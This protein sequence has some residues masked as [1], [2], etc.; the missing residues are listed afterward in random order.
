MK[1]HSPWG[2]GAQLPKSRGIWSQGNHFMVGMVPK[3][4][5]KWFAQGHHFYRFD[6]LIREAVEGGWE[7]HS[8]DAFFVLPSRISFY[9]APCPDRGWASHF[10]PIKWYPL[11]IRSYILP[12]EIPEI[13][14]KK[15]PRGSSLQIKK[16][17]FR[18]T[19]SIEI[20]D[21]WLLKYNL[22]SSTVMHFRKFVFHFDFFWNNFC[23]WSFI[24]LCGEVSTP[25]G[26]DTG[27]RQNLS[28]RPKAGEADKTR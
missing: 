15:W 9:W 4:A 12:D 18:Q 8:V 7:V 25:I 22:V 2:Y 27:G 26:S 17:C 28:P 14:T 1:K 5:P 10:R 6:L 11:T 19:L 21:F 13:M 23:F 24:P 3:N 16:N 20:S